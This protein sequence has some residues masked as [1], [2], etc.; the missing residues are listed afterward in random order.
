MTTK[1]QRE[2]AK[3]N[4]KK[5]QKKWQSMSSRARARAQPEGR[6]RTKPGTTG[7][8]DYYHVTVRPKYQFTSFRTQDVGRDGHTMRVAGHRRSGSWDTH[9]WL[10]HKDDAHVEDGTLVADDP[11]VNEIL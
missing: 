2:A 3:E 9:K 1:E 7:E 6:D 8:G 11:Q 4:I 5:A 10:I